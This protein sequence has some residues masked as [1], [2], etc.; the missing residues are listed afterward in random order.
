MAGGN[1]E[2][3]MQDSGGGG[4]PSKGFLGAL[5]EIQQYYVV[6][7]SGSS[8]SEDF[9]TLQGKLGF[10]SVGVKSTFLIG[11]LSV[12][13]TPLAWAV[14]E[15]HLPTFG[16][17]TPSMYDTV[18]AFLLATSLSLG[19]A[20]FIATLSRYYIGSVTKAAIKNLLSGMIT[21]LIIK[22]V[23]AFFLYFTLYHFVFEP[24]RLHDISMKIL[25]YAT[26]SYNLVDSF[27]HLCLGLRDVMTPS[28]WFVLI[29][30]VLMGLIPTISIL[31]RS[32]KTQSQVDAEV[33]WGTRD[34]GGA[35]F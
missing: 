11:L 19:Y 29:T 17:R 23:F 22:V 4:T 5:A 21:G 30:S 3:I 33:T 32:R 6:E 34:E 2:V 1:N 8:I 35:K 26:N 25:S 18:F 31:L 20:C 13:M 12:F 7:R 10:F 15:Q 14:M 9:L 16:N 27:Y 28:F 24:H